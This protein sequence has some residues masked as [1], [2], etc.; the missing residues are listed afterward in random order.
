MAFGD[1]QRRGVTKE[2]L[3]YL[4]PQKSWIIWMAFGDL[5]WTGVTNEGL[6]YLHPQQSWIIW[7]AFGDL[8]RIGVTNEGLGYLYQQQCWTKELMLPRRSW[9]QS[10][11][12]SHSSNKY[13][14]YNLRSL[15]FRDTTQIWLYCK[16]RNKL[17][18]FK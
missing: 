8:Q 1:L 6:R 15:K 18:S 16:E 3:R 17:L 4:H 9:Q 11:L 7:T 14:K 2:G 12:L 5:Q 13:L 10:S